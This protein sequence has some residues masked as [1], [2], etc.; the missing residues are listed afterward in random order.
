MTEY[1]PCAKH[2]SGYL[3]RGGNMA[4]KFR[5]RGL[6]TLVGRSE[7]LRG[8][9]VPVCT[10]QR[11]HLF[12]EMEVRF[13]VPLVLVIYVLSCFLALVYLTLPHRWAF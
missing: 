13:T 5:P 1:L 10:V 9:A 11:G 12:T 4:Q 6:W 3:E 8:C 2:C 7:E